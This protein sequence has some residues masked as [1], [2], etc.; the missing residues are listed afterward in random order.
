MQICD[1][2]EGRVPA[3]VGPVTAARVEDA[4]VVFE[5]KI[6]LEPHATIVPRF[7]ESIRFS[8]GFRLSRDDLG[9]P[10][11]GYPSAPNP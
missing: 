11:G 8:V 6:A 9:S 10:I 1:R 7:P 2:H 3:T 4:E 5:G